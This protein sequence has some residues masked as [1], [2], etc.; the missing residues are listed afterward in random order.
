MK[1]KEANTIKTAHKERLAKAKAARNRGKEP[2]LCKVL[3][4]IASICLIGGV[5]VCNDYWTSGSG[6][7]ADARQ[8]FALSALFGGIVSF[9][10]LA[11]LGSAL[12]YLKTIAENTDQ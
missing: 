5:M 1:I 3:Y 7:V 10:V 4:T 12:A 2:F 11:A 9:A 6:P 8:S